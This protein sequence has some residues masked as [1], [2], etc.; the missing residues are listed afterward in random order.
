MVRIR[1]GL[2]DCLAVGD[3]GLPIAAGLA[4]A[5]GLATDLATGSSTF[6]GGS[7]FIKPMTDRELL[8]R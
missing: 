7:G 4:K 8:L 5:S 1:V 2:A 6:L 3:P